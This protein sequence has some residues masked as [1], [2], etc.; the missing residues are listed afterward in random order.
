[1][2]QSAAKS[3]AWHFCQLLDAVAAVQR[4]IVE[5]A[6]HTAVLEEVHHAD[7]HAKNF[8]AKSFFQI[9]LQFLAFLR[10]DEVYVI[11]ADVFAAARADDSAALENPGKADEDEIDE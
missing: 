7:F 3:D 4:L 10:R 2:T 8:Q 6:Y 9:C 5:D 1:M 11:V